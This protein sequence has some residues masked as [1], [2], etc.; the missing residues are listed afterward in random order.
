ME[1]LA[2]EAMY[3]NTTSRISRGIAAKPLVTSGRSAIRFLFGVDRMKRRNCQHRI[4]MWIPALT[5]T[6]RFLWSLCTATLAIWI[7]HREKI[8]YVFHE[9]RGEIRPEAGTGL[10]ATGLQSYPWPFSATVF[11]IIQL[12][13]R[14]SESRDAKKL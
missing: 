5:A 14:E 4:Q 8:G 2:V 6:Q 7:K 12:S 11:G 3:E 13:Q 1:T 9:R 10:I